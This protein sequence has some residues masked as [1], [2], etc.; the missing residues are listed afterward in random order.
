[1]SVASTTLG[2]GRVVSKE[3]ERKVI[4]A[5]TALDFTEAPHIYKRDG[6]YHLLV[7]EGGTQAQVESKQRQGVEGEHHDISLWRD[8]PVHLAQQTMRVVCEFQCMMQNHHINT[9]ILKGQL[10]AFAE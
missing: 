5:G 4:F 8:Y 7:A 3:E 1:M 10:A 6:W 9:V 2:D